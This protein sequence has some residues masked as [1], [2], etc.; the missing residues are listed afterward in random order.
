MSRTPTQ[1]QVQKA[2][3]TVQELWS[4]T[5][6]PTREGATAEQVHATRFALQQSLARLDRI[7][8]NCHH[9]KHF[10]IDD[11]ALHKARIPQ[12]FQTVEGQC[13]D[14]RFDGVPF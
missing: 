10:H 5:A 6:D 12:E 13:A 2:M 14:W 1:E 11:C 4:P 7:K 8:T 3:A 9:C